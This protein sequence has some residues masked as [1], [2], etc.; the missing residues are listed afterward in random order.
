MAE[1]AGLEADAFPVDVLGVEDPRGLA[2][3]KVQ[4]SGTEGFQI[5]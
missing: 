2:L 3:E 4:G 1:G 5:R